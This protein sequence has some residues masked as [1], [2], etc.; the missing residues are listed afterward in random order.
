MLAVDGPEQS[1]DSVRTPVGVSQRKLLLV[2][3]AVAEFTKFTDKAAFDEAEF[4]SKDLV[5]VFPHQYQNDLCV[6]FSWIRRGN[7]VSYAGSKQ[8]VFS[9]NFAQSFLNVRG[10]ARRQ[11]LQ[12]GCNG[13]FQG[14]FSGESFLKRGAG[15]SLLCKC[16]Q[17]E[18][19]LA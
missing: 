15:L 5:P 8:P 12:S 1:L 11:N 6:P 13:A 2:S 17:R 9:Q 16:S 18:I 3:P 7:H 14:E 10:K 19:V 4:L